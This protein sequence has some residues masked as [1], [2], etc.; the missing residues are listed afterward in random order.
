M[1][2]L[3]AQLTDAMQMANTKPSG[4]VTPFRLDVEGIDVAILFRK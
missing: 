3:P 4:K 1:S 2:T